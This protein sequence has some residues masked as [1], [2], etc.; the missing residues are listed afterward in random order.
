MIKEAIIRAMNN[1][2]LLYHEAEAVMNEIMS[3]AFTPVQASSFLTAMSMKGE[4]VDEITAFAAIMRRH[5]LPVPRFRD[6][7][8]IVGT[9]G[10][11]SDSFN[12]S[13]VSAFVISAAGVPVA[14]H[15]NRAASSRC[16][17]A[18]VLE[19][20]GADLTMSPERCVDMLD[21]IGICFLFAPRFH[22]AMRHV[23]PVRREMGVRT[24]FNLLGPLTNPMNV[25]TQLLGVYDGSLSKTLAKVMMNLGIRRGMVVHGHDGLD[26]IS[27]CDRTSVCEILDGKIIEYDLDPRDLGFQYCRPEDIRGGDASHNAVIMSE[28]LEGEKGPHRDIVLLNSAAALYIAGMS[29]SL[30]E[31]VS[32]AAEAIDDNGAAG[33][34]ASFIDMSR[35]GCFHHP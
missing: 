7:V 4:T 14:K 2:D 9:G 31:G 25:D 21:G 30:Q 6:A 29:K 23:A 19:S 1:E 27:L 33:K 11:G 34:L 28:V 16:G 8:E 17:A 20:L 26:E 22:Q 12:I 35:G 18:D 5:C 32:M 10:D 13:T 15:G 24:F 3:G